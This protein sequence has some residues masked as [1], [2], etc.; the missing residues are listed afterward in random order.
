MAFETATRF[1][2]FITSYADQPGNSLIL[3]LDQWFTTA[4]NP[5]FLFAQSTSF[6]IPEATLERATGKFQLNRVGR[7]RD[8]RNLEPEETNRQGMD[9]EEGNSGGEC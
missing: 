7:L 3:D 1:V 4:L 2:E 6:G 8:L 5:G 9:E